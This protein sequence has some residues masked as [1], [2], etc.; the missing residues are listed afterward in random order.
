MSKVLD[1]IE[2]LE[3]ADYNC[4]NI[5]RAGLGFVDIVKA[6]IRSA[7]KLLEEEDSE[8]EQP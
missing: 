3:C 6:Q 2:Q 4:D 5:K 8:Q 7:I 1:A